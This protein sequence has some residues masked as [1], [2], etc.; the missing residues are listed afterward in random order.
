MHSHR[1]H[2]PSGPTLGVPCLKGQLSRTTHFLE[3][4]I[5]RVKCLLSPWLA[6]LK[7]NMVRMKMHFNK[8]QR[9]VPEK[10]KQEAERATMACPMD[11]PSVTTN[12]L[13][14]TLPEKYIYQHDLSNRYPFRVRK[15]RRRLEAPNTISLWAIGANLHIT[16][17]Y[18]WDE[19]PKGCAPKVNKSELNPQHNS[20]KWL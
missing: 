3:C 5:L 11:G 17:C 4:Y 9:G 6:E 2:V 7:E 19:P 8:S 15:K 10:P 18:G 16:H 1:S 12:P 14:P 20:V 13:L